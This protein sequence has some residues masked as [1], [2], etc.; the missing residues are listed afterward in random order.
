[1]TFVEWGGRYFAVKGNGDVFDSTGRLEIIPD[2][3]QKAIKEAKINEK[4][5][6]NG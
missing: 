5:D 2:G 6:R 1:M 3:L 4:P